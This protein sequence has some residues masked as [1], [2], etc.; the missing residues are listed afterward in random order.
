MGHTRLLWIGELD[1]G[2]FWI[3]VLLFFHR[4]ERLEAKV[5]KT[6]INEYMA[7]TVQGCVDKL[8]VRGSIKSPGSQKQFQRPVTHSYCF[9]LLVL[10]EMG[11]MIE[12]GFDHF[13]STID[14]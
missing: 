1:G 11:Y 2:E 7:N 13:M 8:D 4:N 10:A 6:S 9:I 14:A 3:G 12:V 5:L